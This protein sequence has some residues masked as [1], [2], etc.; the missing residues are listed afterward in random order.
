MRDIRGELQERASLFEEQIN[1]HEAGFEKHIEQLKR[2]HDSRLED[3]KAELEAVTRLME[4]EL[5]RFGSAP[6]APTVQTR[7]PATMRIN[8][9][10]CINRRSIRR[11]SRCSI[12]RTGRSLSRKSN[13][14]SLLPT[15]WSA[16]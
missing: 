8:R 15:S 2:E 3:L 12:V 6:A 5:R 13:P 1:A 4:I 10:V 7:E 11:I 16:S 14:S 9:A